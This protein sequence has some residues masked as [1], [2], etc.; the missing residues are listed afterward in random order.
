MV[1]Y[2]YSGAPAELPTAARAASGHA[3]S[4]ASNVGKN[5]R[6]WNLACHVTLRL[7]VIR[8]IKELYHLSIARSVTKD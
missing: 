8:A 4:P 1:G 2:L 3:A 5:F 6:R 7:G